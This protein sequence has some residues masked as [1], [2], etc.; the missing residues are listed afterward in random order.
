MRNDFRTLVDLDLDGTLDKQEFAI[1]LFYIDYC[2]AG[3]VLPIE[4]PQEI[5]NA[6]NYNKE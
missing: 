3:G 4:V 2:L 5:I 6:F 1:G